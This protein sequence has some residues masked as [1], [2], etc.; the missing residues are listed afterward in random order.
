MMR[1]GVVVVARD[2]GPAVALIEGNRLWQVAGG[3]EDK[4]GDALGLGRGLDLCHKTGGEALGAVGRG[5]PEAFDLGRLR[6]VAAQS[7]AADGGMPPIGHQKG[8]KGRAHLIQ[9]V[10]GQGAGIKAAGKDACQ[11]GV[12]GAEAG[13]GIG[14]G[15]IGG[16]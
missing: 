2:L 9:P 15:G 3:V 7:H 10:A 4:A 14:M 16:G 12:I 5:D 6:V 11:F 13:E 1:I 8:A